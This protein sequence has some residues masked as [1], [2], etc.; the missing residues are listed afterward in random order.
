M[1][2]LASDKLTFAYLQ[3][4]NRHNYFAT[5]LAAVMVVFSLFWLVFRIGGEIGTCLYADGAFAVASLL[6]AF[7]CFWV[8]RR[9][10]QGSFELDYPYRRAW[11]IMGSGLLAS[12]GVGI[13]Y[14]YER[15]LGPTPFPSVADIFLSLSYLLIFVGLLNMPTLNRLRPYMA[16]D[17]LITVLCFLGVDWFFVIGPIVM[18]LIHAHQPLTPMYMLG[19][20]IAISYSCWDLALILTVVLIIQRQVESRLYLSVLLLGLAAFLHVIADSA[21]TYTNVLGANSPSGNPFA[22]IN[23]LWLISFL[24]IGLSALYQYSALAHQAHQE[25]THISRTI[26]WFV[27]SA[28]QSVKNLQRLQSIFIYFPILFLL[29]LTAF[30]EVYY[31]G[32]ITNYLSVLTATTGILV[33]LRYVLVTTEH[34]SLLRDRAHQNLESDRLRRMVTQLTETLDIRQLREQIVSM[35][36][37]ELGFDAAMFLMVEEQN[38]PLDMLP[39]LFVQC[40]S[41][42]TN[43]MHWRFQGDNILYRTFLTA[44]EVSLTWE[45]HAADIP[46]DVRFWQREESISTMFFF[47]LMYQGKTLGSLGVAYRTEATLSTQD[48]S[49]LRDYTEQVARLIEHVRLYQEARE[50]EA[51]ATAMANIATRL[52]SAIMEVEPAEVSQLICEEGARALQADYALLYVPGS[53]GQLVPAAIYDAIEELV[54]SLGE[55]PPIYMHEYEAQALHSLQPTLLYV[56]S[57]VPAY[58]NQT[59]AGYKA[60]GGDTLDENT[61]PRAAVTETKRRN[62]VVNVMSLREKLA[63]L[64]VRAAILVPLTTGGDSIGILIFA[65][66]QSSKLHIHRAFN[67]FD[68]PQAQDF[69]EQAG[70]AFTNAKLYRSLRTA[71]NRLKELDQMKD[72]FMI[73]AS[74]ELRTPLT[75]VQGYIELMAEYD[76]MLPPD[77]RREF[78]QK[79]RRGCDELAVLLGNVMDASRLEA[80]VEVKAAL[81]KPV[82]VQEVVDGVTILIEPHM[83]QEERELHLL[84]PTHLA[85]RADPL[86]L[87]QVLMNVC[88]NALKY[89]PPRTPIS[90]MARASSTINLAA[91]NSPSPTVT[92]SISD[93]GNGIDPKDQSRIF[94]RFYRLESDLNSPIRGSGL[95]LYISRRLVEAMGGQIWVESKGVPGEGSTFHI[96]LPQAHLA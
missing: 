57:A 90:I 3:K 59:N 28:Q 40:A 32:D 44:K 1:E 54:P 23:P 12:T 14:F 78:L 74:H 58:L 16:L 51:F 46:S 63:T 75:A 49:T 61:A 35:A 43:N 80:D 67:T 88:T 73:T 77:Q 24:L 53:K 55:W 15:L 56:K 2:K 9:A 34:E 84:I 10:Y 30:V 82:Q 45:K 8:T 72:Q 96:Q 85:V 7:G 37:S 25:H 38:H 68:L 83:T 89:S 19:F 4:L 13:V 18:H 79:A 91:S 64:S 93:K 11:R 65:R 21:Y 50:H 86:R 95:G 6:G 60:A 94:Q 22:F 52:N 87:R 70:V 31:D 41:I 27:E 36:V 62:R 66:S 26:R 47:P 20:V 17:A 39:Y 5:A 76:E 33:V 69:G 48:A 29:A 71:H 42:S 81:L 92:I